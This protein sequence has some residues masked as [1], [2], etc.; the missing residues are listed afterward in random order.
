MKKFF[1]IIFSLMLIISFSNCGDKEKDTNGKETTENNGVEQ[2]VKKLNPKT[3]TQDEPI[4]VAKIKE[5]FYS[6]ENVKEITIVGYPNFFFDEGSIG[7]R[8]ELLSSPDSKDVLAE[9]NMKTADEENR[10]KQNT[11]TIRGT[12]DRDFFGKI[13]LKE[14]EFITS[15][16]EAK[17]VDY[18][19]A[20][21]VK[22]ETKYFVEDFHNSFYGWHGK[23]VS[24]VGYYWGT[25]TST[26]D[27]GVTVR[28]DLTDGAGGE[29]CVGCEMK[30]EPPESLPNNR[31]DVIV[32]GKIKGDVFGNV[33]MEECEIMNR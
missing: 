14:C 30:V 20:D 11:V 15:G 28:I 22:N 21:E 17:R 10:N 19:F 27:Y 12:I 7:S 29:K 5:A 26:T 3:I 1:I 9:C 18:I 31:A 8:V 33:Y 32:K 13:I 23:V 16:E 4:P 6:W 25:T 2:K 24:V